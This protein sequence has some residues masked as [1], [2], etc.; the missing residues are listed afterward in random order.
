VNNA[1]SNLGALPRSKRTVADLDGE[2]KRLQE[3]EK[4]L[5]QRIAVLQQRFDST[6]GIQEGY[7]ELQRD[8][9]SAKEDYDVLARRLDEARLAE[10]VETGHQGE[11]F[12]IL[13]AAIPPEGPAAPDRLRLIIM[14]FLLAVAAMAGIVVLAEQVD[15]SFHTVDEVREFTAVPVIAAIPQIGATPRRGWGHAVLST[16]S[17]VA[18]VV[19]VATLSAYLAHGNDTLVRLLNRVG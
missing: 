9:S 2:L 14:G 4:D 8:Y 17:A 13:D 16:A 19:L 1:P 15:T 12:R 7:L 5:R 6:P 3:G 18:A 11:N 10:S